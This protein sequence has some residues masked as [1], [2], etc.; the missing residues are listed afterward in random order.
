MIFKLLLP[1]SL[2][3]LLACSGSKTAYQP[4]STS[5]V[6]PEGY[7][8]V[9]H[10]EFNEE[11]KPDSASWSYENG[12]V[13]NHELQW[14]QPENANIE[15]G[16][17]VIEGKREK[18][19]NSSYE[20]GSKEWK[21]SRA[22]AEYTSASINTKDK[23]HFQYGIVEVRARIDTSQGMWPAI[24]TL[25]ESKG[26]PSNGEID[27]MEFYQIKGTPSILA[28]AA[29]AD[30]ARRAVWDGEGLPLT[31]FLEEDPAWP[32]KF[33][34]WK[35]DWTQE[36]IRLYLDGE[37]LNEI[38]LSRTLN[39][40]GYNPFHQPH[41]VLLNM[42]IGSNGGDPSATTFPGKYEVDYVRVYQ[43]K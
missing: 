32:Q 30:E 39:A 34:E 19:K 20:K 29:W 12:F 4:S 2:A 5:P 16:L 37:L 10:D 28:N 7:K 15:G 43:E 25:G 1:F 13:R 3:G 38:D 23:K 27:I 18:V 40:D 42:A 26:W 33:H 11:G 22:Y 9:W 21:K 6:A 8:L 14:Y 41:Y 17:L 35:M 31:H 24:W 36:Y